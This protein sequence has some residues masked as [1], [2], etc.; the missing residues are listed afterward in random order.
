AK[1]DFV[2]TKTK[3]LIQSF[4]ITSQFVFENIYS[5]FKGDRRAAD[6]NYLYFNNKVLPF[7]DTQQMIYDTSED[8]KNKIKDVLKNNNLSQ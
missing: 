3:Q 1:V 4:P 7:P 5:S 6:D 8:L 2:T